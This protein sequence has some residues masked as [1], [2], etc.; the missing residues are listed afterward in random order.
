MF[1]TNNI[2]QTK[3]INTKLSFGEIYNE[4]VSFAGNR[5]KLAGVVDD[6]IV[7]GDG[8]RFTVFTQGCPHKCPDCHNPQTHDTNGGYWDTIENLFV[9]IASNPLLD[10]VTFSGGEPFLQADVLAVLAK[11]IHSLGLNIITYTGYRFEELYKNASSNN[12]YMDLINESDFL[13]DGR[14]DRN[15]KSYKFNFVGSSNQ[16][17]IDCKKSQFPQLC[18]R[19]IY[20]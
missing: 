4:G 15:K 18:L 5:I 13:I 17:I 9:R 2:V 11:Q 3:N 20:A 10:G 16:R 12:H 6:S 14:F 19:D 7:D 8:V 1:N